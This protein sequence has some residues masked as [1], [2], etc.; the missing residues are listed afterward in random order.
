MVSF[1]NYEGTPLKFLFQIT[2]GLKACKVSQHALSDDP[3][4]TI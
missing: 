1:H 3:N 4:P 2:V